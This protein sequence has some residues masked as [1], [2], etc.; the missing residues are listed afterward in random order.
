MSKL[1]IHSTGIIPF[2]EEMENLFEELQQTAIINTKYKKETNFPPT[3]IHYEEKQHKYI[4]S[5]ITAGYDKDNISVVYD[6]K[7]LTIKG[8]KKR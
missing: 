5:I 4:I 3:D 2:F 1:P 7:T 6:N 8:K